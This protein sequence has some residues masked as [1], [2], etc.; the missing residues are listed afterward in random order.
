MLASLLLAAHGSRGFGRE[1]RGCVRGALCL[2]AAW[3]M[4]LSPP[5][6]VWG[7]AEIRCPPGGTGVP[8]RC[9]GALWSPLRKWL[10]CPFV[11]CL[12]PQGCLQRGVRAPNLFIFLLCQPHLLVP[13]S[14]H[15]DAA[16]RTAGE[17]VARLPG[18]LSV[19]SPSPTPPQGARQWAARPRTRLRASGGVDTIPADPSSSPGP[20]RLPGW[21]H[22]I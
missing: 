19:H 13:H 4:H 20:R 18:P 1:G 22:R 12:H 17:R 15:L 9:P 7:S 2:L 10:Q 16:H 21:A 5:V 6:S 14:F 8:D 11:L 3:G